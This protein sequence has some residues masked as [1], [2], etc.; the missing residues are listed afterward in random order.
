VS[1]PAQV[2]EETDE[3]LAA[4]AAA[5]DDHAFS[6]LYRRHARYVAG[7]IY[8]LVGPSGDIED[9]VQ[10]TFEQA[11][12]GLGSL[13]EKAAVRPWIVTIAIRRVSRRRAGLGLRRRTHDALFVTAAPRSEPA[14]HGELGDLTRAL[15][16]L[17]GKLRVPWVLHRIEGWTLPE[18][19]SATGASLA[20]VK[21][22]IAEAE[23]A[24]EEAFDGE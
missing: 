9:L 11:L 20:T 22:R 4:R 2:M 13:R 17:D 7:V 15:G 10:E 21:R 18:V 5:G 6:Q 12:S 23:R 16:R 19:A 24:I 1:L 14:E 8:R 3:S